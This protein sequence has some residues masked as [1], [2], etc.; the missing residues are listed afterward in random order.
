MTFSKKHT[1]LGI[2]TILLGLCLFA[3]VIVF[4]IY[5]YT[6][7]TQSPTEVSEEINSV[8]ISGDAG[9]LE[10][11]PVTETLVTN[12]TTPLPKQ[13]EIKVDKN[14]QILN[15]GETLTSTEIKTIEEKYNVI[16][17]TD[18]SENGIYVITTTDES[19][20]TTLSEDLDATLETDIPVKMSAD[21][22][23][24][25]V[26]RIGAEKIWADSQGTGV[27]VAV[28]DTGAELTHSDLSANI[29]TGYDFVNNDTNPS[30]DNGH[31]T[32]VSGIIASTQNSAGNIGAAYQAKIMP[33]KVLNNEGYG[34]LSDVAKGIYYAADNG[35]RI[36]NMSLGSSSDSLTLKT[37]IDYAAKKGVL[38]V[39]AAGNE[40]GSSCQYP[41]AYSSVICVG[42]TDTSNKLASFSN[43]GSELSAPGV[44]N[45]STYIGNTYR[46]MS[47]TSMATP[48]VAGA[49]AVVASFCTTCTTAEIRTV[50]K[51]TAVD[52]GTTGYDSVFGY[53]LVDLV[54]AI[55]SLR[56]VEE[57]P[58]ETPTTETPVTETPT[59]TVPDT[60]K[61]QTKQNQPQSIKFVEPETD[62][63]NKRYVPTSVGD[64]T[65]S[66]TLDPVLD[67]TTLSKIVLSMN[68]KTVYETEKQTDEFVLTQDILDHSQHWVRVT[69]YFTDGKRVSDNMVIDLTSLRNRRPRFSSRDVLGAS[70][71]SGFSQFIFGN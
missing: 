71:F 14:R 44:S 28:I 27:K 42:A 62:D 64:I 25:G 11:N 13:G 48:H 24:W 47:G 10:N 29:V 55:N 46:Y 21:T 70:T 50:L 8:Y 4:S 1:I 37:A 43:M 57:V 9:Q 63:T 45:Y 26:A 49:A 52:L 3:L 38:M 39:A 23:D 34:Y 2:S 5:A 36:I 19:N 51:N 20:T 7:N 67:T 65:V 33:I 17:S 31:G 58:V 16:F 40:S 6:Q 18:T 61:N 35:A 54:A 56:P 66:F 69:A 68:N 15:V 41:A 32:H 59:T 53:G 22:I 60:T 12:E 30:D